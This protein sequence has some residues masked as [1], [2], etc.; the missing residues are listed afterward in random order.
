MKNTNHENL[1][2]LPDTNTLFTQIFHEKV[3]LEEFAEKYRQTARKSTH[4]FEMNKYTYGATDVPSKVSIGMQQST[5]TINVLCVMI[6]LM[7]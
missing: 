5:E 6:S 7:V 4:G 3:I 1:S 2:N